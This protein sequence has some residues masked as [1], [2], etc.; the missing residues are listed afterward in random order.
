LKLLSLLLLDH[1]AEASAKKA[2]VLWRLNHADFRKEL[3][4]LGL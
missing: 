1:L 4:K 2:A 3:A